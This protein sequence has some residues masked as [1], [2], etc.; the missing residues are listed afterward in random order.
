MGVDEK[1]M[2]ESEHQSTAKGWYTL[3]GRKLFEKP[4]QPGLY[5]ANGKKVLVK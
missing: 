3:D 5:I 1:E 4:A 2:V